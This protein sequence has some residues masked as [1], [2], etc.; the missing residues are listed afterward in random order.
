MTL[1]ETLEAALARAPRPAVWRFPEEGLELPLPS[2]V[3]A[4]HGYASAFREL[5]VGRADRVG[6][7]LENGS[8]YPAILLGLW[9]LGAIAVPLRPHT[10]HH[11]DGGASL[12]RVDRA[13][14]LSVV[15]H[16]DDRDEPLFTSWARERGRA[17][18]S[19]MTRRALRERA[20]RLGRS[21][22]GDASL[23]GGD[24]AVV[25]YSSGSTADPKG[26]IVTH[27]MIATQAEQIHTEF[28]GACGGEPLSSTGSWL[29]FHHDMGLFIGVLQPLSIACDNVLASP[30]FYMYRPKRWF[31]LQAEHR[32]QW[33]FT[34]NLAMANSFASLGQLEPGSLDLSRFH[35]YLAAEKVSPVV[36]RR[37]WEV[38]G[39]FGM[40]PE[41]VKVGYGMAENAL[42]VTSTKTGVVRTLAVTVES[43]SL[44]R[45]AAADEPDA[46]EVVSV[47]SAHV[48][49]EVAVVD[50][51][52]ARLPDLALGEITVRSRCVT[53]GYYRDPDGSRRTIKDR[54]LHTRDIGFVHEGELYFFARKDD[55]LVVGGRNIAPDDI[56]RCAE[57]QDGFAPGSAVL[58]D[59]PIADTGKTELVLLVEPPKQLSVED[60]E[61]RKR[62]LQSTIFS[63]RGV[64]VNRVVFAAR[65]ALEKTTSGKKRRRLIRER[66]L[67]RE[68][69]LR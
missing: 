27:E 4:S 14:E 33:N 19:V 34:T 54:V 28:R 63:E 45:L 57:E 3:E 15:L 64:L 52:G 30:R 48:D 11:N 17:P 44:L 13:C 21:T 42:G 51:A 7:A 68:L 58:I 43:E 32:V 6:L 1:V 67:K 24:I 8:D 12:T 40:P 56:E 18:G 60:A 59:V 47:G 50:E 61:A 16:N 2:I 46:V 39:R 65:N 23:Q 49:T 9:R 55:V 26:I 66:F 69:P 29:P 35:L 36:L 22:G 5:G 53:P 10:G 31:A 41:N 37:C 25:Q 38:L 20:A 62:M